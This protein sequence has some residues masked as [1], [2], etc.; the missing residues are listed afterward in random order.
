MGDDDATPSPRAPDGC[1]LLIEISGVV[2]DF[3]AEQLEHRDRDIGG[4]GD[5]VEIVSAAKH[6]R[7]KLH[8]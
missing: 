2:G 5:I 8:I 6:Q 1:P 7:R 4:H 3:S